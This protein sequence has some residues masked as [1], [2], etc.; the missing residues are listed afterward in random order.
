MSV[1]ELKKLKLYLKLL[2]AEQKDETF[3]MIEEEYIKS[4]NEEEDENEYSREMWW[5]KNNSKWY[6]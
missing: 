2:E 6:L 3:R 5:T 1:E 4:L